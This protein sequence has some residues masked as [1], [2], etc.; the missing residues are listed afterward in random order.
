MAARF[1]RVILDI[2]DVAVMP[3][4][5]IL[6]PQDLSVILDI[7]QFSVEDGVRQKSLQQDVTARLTAAQRTALL[8]FVQN[9]MDTVEGA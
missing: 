8:A 5:N 2:G 9:C 4:P 6:E 1:S 3:R 7:H